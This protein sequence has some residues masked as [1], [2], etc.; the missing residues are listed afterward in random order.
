MW[1]QTRSSSRAMKSASASSGVVGRSSTVTTREHRVGGR[2]PASPS[3]TGGRPG[4]GSVRA[5]K[6]GSS[7]GAAPPRADREA[8]LGR[9]VVRHHD[10]V[11]AAAVVVDDRRRDGE[12]ERAMEALGDSLS[13]EVTALTRTAPAA[14]AMPKKRE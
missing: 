4:R 13:G 8:A 3:A 12:P 7:A 9:Q 1:V 14:R 5:T 6:R 11:A 2:R 10:P